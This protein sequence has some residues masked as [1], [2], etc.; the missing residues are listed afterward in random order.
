MKVLLADDDKD[1][2]QLRGLLLATSGFE[3]IEV[4]D[5]ASALQAAEAQRPECAVVDLF[6]PT[7]ELG[8]H[9]IRALKKLNEAIRVIVLTG[10]D[11]LRIGRLPEK[12]LVDEIIVKGSSAGYLLQKLRA[13]AGMMQPDLEALARVLGEKGSVVFD[14]KAIPRST[15][16]EIIGTMPDGALKVKIA[17]VPDK[18][19]ANEEL[20]SLL[21]RCFDV[22]KSHVELV[23]GET[24]H[25][26]RV[27]IWRRSGL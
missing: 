7:E 12:N 21:A 2:L 20:K 27:R 26:K 19:K 22:P 3:T 15:R 9:L 13:M 16:S 25:R 23:A 5:G 11:P 17:A 4:S 14:V 18:G 6:F 1:Q 10:G 8:L 24:S